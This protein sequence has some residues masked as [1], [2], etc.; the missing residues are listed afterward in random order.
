M[1]E[2]GPLTNVAHG[3]PP[4]PV[5]NCELLVG[6]GPCRR[7]SSVLSEEA[8]GGVPTSLEKKNTSLSSSGLHFRAGTLSSLALGGGGG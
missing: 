7:K 3:A 1:S 6:P 4:V 2:F 5:F 8:F